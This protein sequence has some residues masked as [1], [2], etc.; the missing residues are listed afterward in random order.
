MRRD[1][2]TV[3]GHDHWAVADATPTAQP[4]AAQTAQPAKSACTAAAGKH[5]DQGRTCSGDQLVQ[6]AGL[7]VR[8]TLAKH[9]SHHLRERRRLVRAESLGHALRDGFA[10]RFLRDAVEVFFGTG[11]VGA[12]CAAHVL[13]QQIS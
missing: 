11:R 4:A 5:A 10:R 9:L 7:L 12:L 3:T 6:H 8:I 13:L 1:V 2:G